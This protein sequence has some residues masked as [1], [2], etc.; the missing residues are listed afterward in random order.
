MKRY[1]FALLVALFAFLGCT[2]D[3]ETFIP[4]YKIDGNYIRDY[5]T[6]KIIYEIDTNKYTGIIILGR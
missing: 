6:G 4:V 1:I 3:Y 2:D 5:K